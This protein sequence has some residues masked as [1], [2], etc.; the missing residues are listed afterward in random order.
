M[1]KI[2]FISHDA[3]RTGAPKIA[4]YIL[5]WLKL[6]KKDVI[7]DTV[8]IEG[9]IMQKSFEDFSNLVYNYN[10]F[11]NTKRPMNKW[12]LKFLNKIGKGPT[13]G[14]QRFF[15]QLLDNQYDIVYVNSVVSLP[16]AHAIKDKLP[17]SKLI[18]HVHELENVISMYLPNFKSYL[19]EVDAYIAASNLVKKNLKSNHGIDPKKI[20]VIYE[21]SEI[22]ISNSVKTE[23]DTFKIGASGALNWRKG[24]D[25]FVQVVIFIKANYPQLKIEFVWIGSV[26]N[27]TLLN[28]A[29]S[30]LEKA[31][32]EDAISF[33]GEQE[34]PSEFY[35]DLDVFL[36]TSRE[37]PFPLVC[38]EI[39]QLE[40]PIIC[41]KG[42][43][44]TEE[45]LINGGGCIVPYLDVK[46]MAEKVVHYYN[47]R[48][49][50]KADGEKAK[51]LFEELT[52][53]NMCPLIF[54]K[55]E[56]LLN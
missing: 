48:E 13:T 22:G 8:L 45:L 38:I 11:G 29:K 12:V 54:D 7:V 52:P 56:Q 44:G 51:Q 43:T 25:L 50:M 9:G 32:F 5:E 21:F 24:F 42:A 1:K 14:R 10:A 27:L 6:N 41:F 30:D 47:N 2:L 34:S 16:V 31:G 15:K 35:K 49:I 18:L 46:A 28:M 53:K 20:D 23:R 40:K 55:I 3:S 26:N 33:V 39:A 19:G 4:L 36:M 17:K 37:D